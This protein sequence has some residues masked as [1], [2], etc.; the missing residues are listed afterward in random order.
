M[1]IQHLAKSMLCVFLATSIR[2]PIPSQAARTVE[3]GGDVKALVNLAPVPSQGAK[4]VLRGIVVDHTGSVVPNFTVQ[5]RNDTAANATTQHP[6]AATV[7]K[8]QTDDAGQFSASLSPGSYVICVARFPK[9]CRS[10][11]VAEGAKPQESV[12][13]EI[14]PSEDHASS[15]LLDTHIRDI[16]GPHPTDCGRVNRE[17]S[18]KQATACAL[19]AYKSHKGFFVRYDDKGNGDSEGAH[20]IAGDAS[21]KVYSVA[22]DSMGLASDYLPP[23][24]TMPDGFH[25]IIIPCSAPVRLRVSRTTGELICFANDRWLGDK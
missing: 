20:G 7:L 9:S 8:V 22:F 3:A 12:R 19:R 25:T 18:P 14:N 4:P 16:A 2:T 6:A 21:G 5:I 1:F 23:G 11:V 10:I 24:A 15:E 17:Q 13:L